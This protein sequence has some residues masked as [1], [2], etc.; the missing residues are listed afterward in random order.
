VAQDPDRFDDPVARLG[1]RPRFAREHRPRRGFGIAGV[2]LAEMATALAH[3]PGDLD[4]PD[5]LKR[6]EASEAGAI[7]AG[8]LNTGHLDRAAPDR[9]ADQRPVAPTRGR[10]RGRRERAAERV[11]QRRGVGVQVG[12]DSEDDLTVDAWHRG[13]LRSCSP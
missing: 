2:V 12:I 10:H 6:E 8:A 5:S 3:R 13:H 4:D 1:D 9:P 11:D 7:R